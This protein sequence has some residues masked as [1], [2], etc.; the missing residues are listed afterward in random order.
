MTIKLKGGSLSETFLREEDGKKIVRKSVSLVRNREYGFQRWYSQMKRLQRYSVIVPGLFPNVLKYGVGRDFAYFD[1]N[2]IEDSVN[3]QEYL[4]AERD[5]DKI[6]VFFEELKVSMRLLHDI[7]LQSCS[8]AMELYVREEVS[9]KIND[10]ISSEKFKEFLQYKTIVFNGEEIIS[11]IYRMDDFKQMLAK[12]YVDVEET[13]SHGNLTLENLLFVPSQNKIVFIDPYEENIIDSRLADYSQLLQSSNS[14]YE[15]LNKLTPFVSKNRV[16]MFIDGNF[17]VDYFNDLL[18]EYLVETLSQSQYIVVK[19]LE[20]S[21]FIRML[22]FKKEI[23]EDKM[24]LF[25]S[26]ASK[27]FARFYG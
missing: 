24:I 16:E 5:A 27:L 8:E 10:S 13:Y 6:G 22:P 7:K 17:G 4:A 23:D 15:I 3:A 26:L 19:L 18:E 20:I 21:Q 2:F 9:Q 25:Y 12:H 1:M 14:K 11:F